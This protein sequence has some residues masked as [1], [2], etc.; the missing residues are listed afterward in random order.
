MAAGEA[1]AEGDGFTTFELAATLS[2]VP[3]YRAL[4]FE[5]REQLA[6]ALPDGV[7]LPVVRMDRPIRP[8][9]ER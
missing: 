9:P 3:F 7:E 2:G 6:V 1:A 8:R 4:G 5:A